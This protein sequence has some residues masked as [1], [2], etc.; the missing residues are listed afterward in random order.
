MLRAHKQKH[1]IFQ[2]HTSKATI[3]QGGFNLILLT[4]YI[5]TTLCSKHA[6]YMKLV[7]CSIHNNVFVT[8]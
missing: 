8:I 2:V 7:R 6:K 3:I 1:I 4:A 5:K